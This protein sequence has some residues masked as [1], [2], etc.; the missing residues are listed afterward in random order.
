M[1]GYGASSRIKLVANANE[2]RAEK[3]KKYLR[4]EYILFICF[5][6]K[7]C[8]NIQAPAET[9]LAFG[10]IVKGAYLSAFS[11]AAGLKKPPGYE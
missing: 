5:S 3:E 8:E 4:L 9:V 2:R 6:P 7:S 1:A 11:M 10:G